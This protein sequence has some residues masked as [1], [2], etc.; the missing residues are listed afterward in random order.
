M[1][2]YMHFPKS[3]SSPP[4]QDLLFLSVLHESFGRCLPWQLCPP[5]LESA[6]LLAAAMCMPPSQAGPQGKGKE[7]EEKR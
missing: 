1:L 2:S 6:F 3:A 7:K 4:L 5:S